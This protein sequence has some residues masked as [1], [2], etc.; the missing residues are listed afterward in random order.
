MYSATLTTVTPEMGGNS[1]A[2]GI[3]KELTERLHRRVVDA[4][5]AD[6]PLQPRW[7]ELKL[8]DCLTSSLAD[9]TEQRFR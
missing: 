7:F 8:P 4:H 1:Q 9:G 5:K 2:E 3:K 6:Q